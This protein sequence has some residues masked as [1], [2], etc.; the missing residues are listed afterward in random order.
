MIRRI[1]RKV[2]IKFLSIVGCAEALLLLYC[3]SA[4]LDGIQGLIKS[5]PGYVIQC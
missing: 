3:S 1:V 4:V 2:I 5:Q